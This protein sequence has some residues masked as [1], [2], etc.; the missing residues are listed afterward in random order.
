MYKVRISVARLL[1]AFVVG[2]PLLGLAGCG[3]R[4]ATIPPPAPQEFRLRAGDQVR[5]AIWPDNELELSGE[6][7]VEDDG[8]VY[9]PLVGGIAVADMPLGELRALLRELYSSTMKEPVVSVTPVFPVSVLGAVLRPGVYRVT[10]TETLFDVIGLAGGFSGNANQDKVHIV[11]DG[12]VIELD[13]TLTSETAEDIGLHSGDRVIVPAVRWRLGT[14]DI[15]FALQ[16]AVL[17]ITLV[18]RL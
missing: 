9:L 1:G 15:L 2:L 18:N 11:R 7:S 16:S 10:P 17:I 4:I 14:R 8:M 3:P 12:E 13:A 5:I 6:Y